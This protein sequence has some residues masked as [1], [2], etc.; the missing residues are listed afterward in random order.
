MP[1]GTWASPWTYSTSDANGKRVTV[2]VPF[3]NSTL[4]IVNP[5]LSGTRDPGCLYDRVL[6][7]RV[8]DGN[9]KV[10]LIPEGDFSVGRAQLANQGFSTIVQLAESGFTLGTTETPT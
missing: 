7:G 3:N 4:A 10:W 8:A 1:R 9:Q 5:G 2:Q 6:I